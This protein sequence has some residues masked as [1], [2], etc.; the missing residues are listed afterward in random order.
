[1]LAATSNP[2][3]QRRSGIDDIH[4]R[5]MAMSLS[6]TSRAAKARAGTHIPGQ[7][8]IAALIGAVSNGLG[9][10]LL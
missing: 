7:R 4:A 9:H 3:E 2:T 1:M 6:A 8:A 5:A 10:A